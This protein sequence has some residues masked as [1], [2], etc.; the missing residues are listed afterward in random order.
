[1][2]KDTTSARLRSSQANKDNVYF[3]S[4]KNILDSDSEN[5]DSPTTEKIVKINKG[6]TKCSSSA[7][8]MAYY[9]R[10]PSPKIAF[11]CACI[12]FFTLLSTA[13]LKRLFKISTSLANEKFLELDK[14]PACYGVTLCPS[15]LNGEIIPNSL[16][17]FLITQ[18]L[19]SKNVFYAQFLKKQVSYLSKI[20]KDVIFLILCLIFFQVVLK[21]LA[22]YGEL[23]QLDDYLLQ[24]SAT[25]ANKSPTAEG[26]VS[27]AI[28]PFTRQYLHEEYISDEQ[29]NSTY[30]SQHLR[31]FNIAS[32]VDPTNSGESNYLHGSDMLVCPSQRKLDYIEE[33]FVQ[34]NLGL[35]RLTSLDNLM[36]ILL[37][38][39]EPLIL[40]V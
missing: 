36:T 19:N 33:K 8:Q 25:L 17:A 10:L 22:H 28:R 9:S 21:K 39:S 37:L 26:G 35:N 18:L 14:C 30:L 13:I 29:G 40:Q 3:Q 23:D 27:G 34:N 24:F 2:E 20:F 1:M 5:S 4:R 11:T 6:S 12:V 31:I 32:H 16:T 38:N 15:F 7:I